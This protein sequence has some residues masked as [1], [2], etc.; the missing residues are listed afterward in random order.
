MDGQGAG[1]EGG[2]DNEIRV[3]PPSLPP[4]LPPAVNSTSDIHSFI[5][6]KKALTRPS[7][8]KF[9]SRSGR[10]CSELLAGSS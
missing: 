9:A 7:L 2:R 8:P 1:W 4:Y 5:H 3:D 10:T 6:T